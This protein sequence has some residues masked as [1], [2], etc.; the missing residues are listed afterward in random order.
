MGWWL[1]VGD[2]LA[3]LSGT[4]RQV[5]VL[6]ADA[7]QSTTRFGWAVPIGIAMVA[8]IAMMTGQSVVLA[9]NKVSRRRGL[10]TM[11]ASGVAML[12]IGAI[13]ALIVSGLG[14]LILGNSHHVT[15]LLPS[16]LIAFAPYWLGFLV[17]LPYTGP[18]VAR[19]LEV[20]HLLA[21]WMLLIPVLATTPSGALAVA[22]AAWL[23]TVLLALLVDNSPLR[24]RERFFRWVS[25][26]R[27]LTPRDMLASAA[28]EADR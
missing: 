9:I 11:L 28:W 8:G 5:L 16:V 3:A 12:L 15:E 21:L 7:L 25:G 26:T 6:N 24:L 4:A 17:L 22:A 27:G 20:W 23:S 10:L 1:T 18:G 19:L 14:R 2:Y 13:E